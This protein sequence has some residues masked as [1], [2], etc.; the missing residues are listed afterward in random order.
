MYINEKKVQPYISKGSWRY[1]EDED[2]VAYK[3]PSLG[4]YKV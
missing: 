3:F 1:W 4:K 2:Y